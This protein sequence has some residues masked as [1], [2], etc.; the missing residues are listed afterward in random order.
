MGGGDGGFKR[1]PFGAATVLI[2]NS[3]S[4]EKS[5][6]IFLNQITIFSTLQRY[7]NRKSKRHILVQV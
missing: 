6:L 3:V 7:R 2:I 4:G 1:T 5:L